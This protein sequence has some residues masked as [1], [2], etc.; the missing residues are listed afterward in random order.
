METPEEELWRLRLQETHFEELKKDIDSAKVYVE[1]LNEQINVHQAVQHF[2][3]KRLE[4]LRVQIDRKN[5]IIGKLENKVKKLE[6]DQCRQRMP[7]Y[8][9]E[10]E[11]PK[12]EVVSLSHRPEAPSKVNRN[13]SCSIPPA[14][15]STFSS[16]PWL[17]EGLEPEII[18]SKEQIPNFLPKPIA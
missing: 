1:T 16:G 2:K 10:I 17:P 14:W 6:Q 3:D 9:V 7:T 15:L 11:T 4:G 5:E 8:G 13:G 12:I 18:T